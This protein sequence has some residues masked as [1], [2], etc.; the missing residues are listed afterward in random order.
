MISRRNF[1][2]SVFTCC[3]A[4]L[5]WLNFDPAAMAIGGNLLPVNQPAPFRGK[6]VVLYFYPKDF[7]ASC[8]LEARRFQPDLPKYVD[9]NTQIIGVSADSVDFHALRSKT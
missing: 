4:V 8:T 3:F 7:T 5:A 6:W 9:K 1:L 2:S